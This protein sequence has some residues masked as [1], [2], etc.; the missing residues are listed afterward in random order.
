MVLKSPFQT[1]G[2]VTIH[3]SDISSFTLTDGSFNG[4]FVGQRN[5]ERTSYYV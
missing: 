4:E 5:Y 1:T 3:F 2:Y